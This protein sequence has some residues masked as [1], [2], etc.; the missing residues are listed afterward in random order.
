MS[1]VVYVRK[2][3]ILGRKQPVER[4]EDIGSQ[5]GELLEMGPR[6]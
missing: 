1:I 2:L 3:W 4:G 6:S 5:C